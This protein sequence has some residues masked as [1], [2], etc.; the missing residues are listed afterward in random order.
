MRSLKKASSSVLGS[1]ARPCSLAATIPSA[2]MPSDSMKARYARPRLPSGRRASASRS[3]DYPR[4]MPRA[5]RP[6]PPPPRQRRTADEAR[7]EILDAAERILVET[8]PGAIRLQQVAELVGVSH[9]TV[10]H[11][12]GT[13]EALVAA[14]VE[15]A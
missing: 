5:R 13:R 7:A 12:F 1:V 9:P 3:S 4:G 14:V 2:L 6:P 11:H 8:G 15:R 10:L